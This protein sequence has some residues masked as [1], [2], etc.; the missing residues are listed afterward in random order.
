MK[1]SQ[2]EVLL[3]IAE[4]TFAD[5]DDVMAEMRRKL[6]DHARRILDDEELLSKAWEVNQRDKSRF[7]PYMPQ[8]HRQTGQAATG[9]TLAEQRTA[10]AISQVKKAENG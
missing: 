1:P 2:A 4:N 7:A 9:R 3:R 6:A 5:G 10:M 8:E